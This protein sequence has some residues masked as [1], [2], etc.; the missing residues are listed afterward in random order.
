MVG[1]EGDAATGMLGR[2]SYLL[3]DTFLSPFL[4]PTVRHWAF[5]AHDSQWRRYRRKSLF[6]LRHQPQKAR[7]DGACG[8]GPAVGATGTTHVA[9][10]TLLCC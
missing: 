1:S 3:G 10:A 8:A 2:L 6:L 7:H 4:F 5:L 9:P